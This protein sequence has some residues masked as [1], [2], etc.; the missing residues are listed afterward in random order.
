[1]AQPMTWFFAVKRDVVS[2][3]AYLFDGSSGTNRVIYGGMG[4]ATEI[5]FFAGTEVADVLPTLMSTSKFKAQ[6]L[7]NG[8]SSVH[9]HNGVNRAAAATP[10]AGSSG[11]ISLFTRFAGTLP[12]DGRCY[13]MGA[14]ARALDAAE[15]QIIDD[16][17]DEAAEL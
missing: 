6:L 12:Y 8:A 15:T 3:S 11:G 10:G 16:F 13:A 14:F 1:M 7:I 2:A 9:R 5:R 17:L 4:S